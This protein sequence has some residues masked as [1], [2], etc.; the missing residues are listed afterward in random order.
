[1]TPT[2]IITA[3][4]ARRAKRV[5]ATFAADDSTGTWHDQF[6]VTINSGTLDLD[7]QSQYHMTF[8]RP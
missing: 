2:N 6:I 7:E 4:R 5:V 3:R 8:A 1:M